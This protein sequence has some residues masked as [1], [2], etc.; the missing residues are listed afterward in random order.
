MLIRSRLLSHFDLIRR[1]DELSAIDQYKELS[2]TTI[3]NK[4]LHTTM[5]LLPK[6][7][8]FYFSNYTSIEKDTRSIDYK[9]RQTKEHLIREK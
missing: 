1:L 2:T 5:A 7:I 6:I 8:S 9:K 3:T 4:L